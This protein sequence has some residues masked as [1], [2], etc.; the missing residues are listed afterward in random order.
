MIRTFFSLLWSS[1]DRS[2]DYERIDLPFPENVSLPSSLN[3]LTPEQAVELLLLFSRSNK[4]GD[5]YRGSIAT[6]G[7]SAQNPSD[8]NDESSSPAAQ[9]A[10]EYADLIHVDVQTVQTV[11]IEHISTEN[12]SV[13]ITTK[14]EDKTAAQKME[15]IG[16]H[17]EIEPNVQQIARVDDDSQECN[18]TPLEEASNVDTSLERITVCEIGQQKIDE[19]KQLI[20]DTH[21][22][23]AN[24]VSS[25]ERLNTIDKGKER[26]ASV[27]EMPAAGDS[28]SVDARGTAVQ[29]SAASSSSSCIL[30]GDNRAGK[31]RKRPAPRAPTASSETTNDAEDMDEDESSQNALKATLVIKTG[32]LRTV[33]NPDATRDIFLARTPDSTKKRKKSNRL[34]AKE[35]FNKL[36]TIP[37]NIFHNAFHKEQCEDSSK[38][39]DSSST[40]S[41]TSE[42]ASRSGS[43]G[44]QVFVDAKLS[45][46]KQEVDVEEIPLRPEREENDK[47]PD[48]D[49]DDSIERS[50]ARTL[51]NDGAGGIDKTGTDKTADIAKTETDSETGVERVE[52]K[53]SFETREISRPR[54]GKEIITD[55]D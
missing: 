38:E 42:S 11:E 25:Q 2:E 10:G 33:S 6:G 46:S 7:E 15:K 34:R 12:L 22:A 27:S 49:I 43:V 48:Q 30:D 37:K 20:D 28:P 17:L 52:N 44:S 1:K 8:A 36:L 53:F 14:S 23:V 19:L 24:I 4:L 40:F 54:G 50:V 5:D 16:D 51:N 41:G 35:G 3:V 31:Y 21:R 39:E 18:A 13:P 26:D 9:S 55:I 29:H 45:P 32:T 47:K